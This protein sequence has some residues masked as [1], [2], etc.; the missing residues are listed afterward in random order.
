[1]G[2]QGGAAE[3]GADAGASP[4]AV[5]ALDLDRVGVQQLRWPRAGDWHLLGGG[6]GPAAFGGSAVFICTI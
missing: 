3:G 2:A 1:M 6:E 5:G 4:S